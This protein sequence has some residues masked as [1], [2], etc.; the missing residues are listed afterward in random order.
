MEFVVQLHSDSGHIHVRQ[1]WPDAPIHRTVAPEPT[2]DASIFI[3]ALDDG[4]GSKVYGRSL[5]TA[6]AL[7]G[8]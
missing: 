6:L 7:L 4:L 5:Q 1:E 8:D 3:V 2:D